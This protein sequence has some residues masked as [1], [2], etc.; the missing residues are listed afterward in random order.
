MAVLPLFPEHHPVSS[1]LR[2]HGLSLHGGRPIIV[3][4]VWGET[5]GGDGGAVGVGPATLSQYGRIG[6][7]GIRLRHP[8]GAP[9]G[10][11]AEYGLAFGHTAR[12]DPVVQGGFGK[13]HVAMVSEWQ[14]RAEVVVGHDVVEVDLIALQQFGRDGVPDR[15]GIFARGYGR[16]Q[17]ISAIHVTAVA[18]LLHEAGECLRRSVGC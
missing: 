3:D 4:R 13:R 1:R 16:R 5:G 11:Y 6:E 8:G 12:I 14:R 9:V 17:I 7:Y 10:G 18:Q 15:A 2:K